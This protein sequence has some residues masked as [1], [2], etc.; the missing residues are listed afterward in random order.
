MPLTYVIVD[1][2]ELLED[3]ILSSF[4]SPGTPPGTPGTPGTYPILCCPLN[5]LQTCTV[6][7]TCFCSQPNRFHYVFCSQG[8]TLFFLNV[9]QLI[10]FWL[11]GVLGPLFGCP[12]V[13]MGPYG[14][15]WAH[16]G[17][18]GLIWVHMGPYGAIGAHMSPYG[19][20]WSHHMG[21][22]GTIYTYSH[23]RW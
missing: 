7:F 11:L 20:I 13:H 3:F 8:P 1:L 15:I 16:M 23:L 19:P 10:G 22:Y 12:W 18:Y 5:V 9:F 14:S 4:L 6:V 17:P 2:P 21:P